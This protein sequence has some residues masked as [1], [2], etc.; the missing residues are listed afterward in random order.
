MKKFDKKAEKKFRLKHG[1]PK[2]FDFRGFIVYCPNTQ[3]YLYNYKLNKYGA[4]IA[5]TNDPMSSYFDKSISSIKN[6]I[7][8]LELSEIQVMIHFIS[9]NP[10][11]EES[12]IEVKNKLIN[13][14]L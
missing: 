12:R 3:D 7:K 6:L 10:I 13:V 9:V 11:K 14:D 2:E 1:I 4:F 5:Y 8:Q